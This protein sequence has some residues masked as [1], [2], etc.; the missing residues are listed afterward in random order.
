MGK[1]DVNSTATALSGG[2]FKALGPLYLELEKHLTL[3]TY[4][5]GGYDVSDSDKQ[6]YSAIRANTVAMGFLRKGSYASVS[7]WFNY[8]EAA[9]PEVKDEIAN[10]KKKDAKK[11]A[12][13]NIGLPNTENGVVTRFPPEPSYVP[14]VKFIFVWWLISTNCTQ[15]LHAHRSHQGGPA[16]RLFCQHRIRRTHDYALRRHK[17]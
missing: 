16:Q 15:R 8:T 9:H 5:D 14:F 17:P 1:L 4:I 2:D 3:R 6:I 13:Y 11:G 12:N 10:A 7:R